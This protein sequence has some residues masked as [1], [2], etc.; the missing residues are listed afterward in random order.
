MQSNPYPTYE[1]TAREYLAKFAVLMQPQPDISGTAAQGVIDLHSE[2]VIK[3]AEEIADASSRMYELAQSFL[4]SADPLVREGIRFHFI[5]QAA[6]ELLVG[7]ELLQISE[8]KASTPTAALKATHSAALRDAMSAVEKSSSTPIAQGLPAVE[9]HRASESATLNEAASG[10]RLALESAAGNISH[11]V[12]ELGGDIAFDLVSG[13]QW[14]EVLHGASLSIEQISAM[15]ESI[16]KGA[17]GKILLYVYRKVAALLDD[18]VGVEA[19]TKIRDWLQQI[20]Q[21]DRIDVFNALVDNLFKVETLKNSAGAIDGSSAT[22]ESV[23][24]AT[25]LIKA[26]CDRFI[27]LI[28]RMRKLEDAIRL[29]KPIETPQFRPV[30]IA[31]QVALLSALVYSGRDY[32][33]N[34]LTRILHEKGIG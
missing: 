29:G 21:A 4:N 24:K 26:L 19:Q 28:G 30:M 34:G 9:S 20:K 25:D 10:L 32:I 8:D 17:A 22:L 27:V 14:D 33:H 11:R 13:M 23:N 16:R 7:I 12:Q 31:L 5:D 2:V 1:E 6:I 15:L 18:D 3:K